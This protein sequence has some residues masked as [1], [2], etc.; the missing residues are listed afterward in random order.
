MPAVVTSSAA[1]LPAEAYCPLTG[2]VMLDPVVTED[3]VAYE[4]AAISLWLATHG[5]SPK[6]GLPLTSRRL[7][8]VPAVRALTRALMRL[9]PL[10]D[11]ADADAS[12]PAPCARRSHRTPRRAIRVSRESSRDVLSYARRARSRYTYATWRGDRCT[13]D[14]TAPE[15]PS[16]V[17]DADSYPSLKMRYQVMRHL[18]VVQAGRT[19]AAVGDEASSKR[20]ALAWASRTRNRVDRSPSDGSLSDEADD[21]RSLHGWGALE[22]T[23]RM[24]RLCE[25]YTGSWR[26]YPYP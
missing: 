18:G 25:S 3:G 22:H 24:A 12:E 14:V 20:S 11:D 21:E 4:R 10:G 6:T 1:L 5:T 7:T 16:P 13:E 2:R 9:Q 15:S 23:R 17:K 8:P 26:S 19:W